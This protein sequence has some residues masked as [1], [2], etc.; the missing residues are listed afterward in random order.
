MIMAKIKKKEIRAFNVEDL[1]SRI[2]ELRRELMKENAQVATG[3][4]PKSPGLIRSHKKNI[5]R[6][7]TIIKEK[8]K[9]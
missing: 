1:K 5:A 2:E 4:V 3:T 9:K 6:M 8:S 7:L